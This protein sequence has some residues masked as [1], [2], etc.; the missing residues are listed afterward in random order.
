MS[1]ESEEIALIL[2]WSKTI[3]G[4]DSLY[5]SIATMEGSKLSDFDACLADNV[6][7]PVKS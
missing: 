4:D 2:G 7:G 3:S 6:S 1:S 5:M